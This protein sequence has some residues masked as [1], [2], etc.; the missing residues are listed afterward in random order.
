MV[1]PNR[2]LPATMTQPLR[3]FR[4]PAF[5]KLAVYRRYGGRMLRS[6]LGSG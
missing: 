1:R 4:F 3:P 5:R 6:M 2:V